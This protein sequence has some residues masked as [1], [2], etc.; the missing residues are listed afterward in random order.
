MIASLEKTD[1]P[2]QMFPCFLDSFAPFP[3]EKKSAPYFA[4]LNHLNFLRMKNK[5]TFQF[6]NTVIV[7]RRVHALFFCS[8]CIARL[9]KSESQ[10]DR[11]TDRPEKSKDERTTDGRTDISFRFSQSFAIIFATKHLSI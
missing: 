2:C 5:R 8:S 7:L 3:L 9:N 11:Q 1:N 4:M 6:A 10:T